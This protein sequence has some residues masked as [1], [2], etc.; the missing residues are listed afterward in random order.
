MEI[1]PIKFIKWIIEK[2][3]NW[4]NNGAYMQDGHHYSWETLQGKFINDHFPEQAIS[5]ILNY[6]Y[7]RG[8]KLMGR[9]FTKQQLDDFRKSGKDIIMLENFKNQNELK[10]T[11]RNDVFCLIDVRDKR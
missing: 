5:D 9:Y 4:D 10:Q 3:D 6:A 11:D 7:S 8:V 2:C 1:E